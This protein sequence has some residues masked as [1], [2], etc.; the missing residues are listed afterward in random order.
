MK[1][2]T[3]KWASVLLGLFACMLLSAQSKNAALLGSWRM[4]LPDAPYGY[5]EG[6]VK[7]EEKENKLM[8]ISNTA[9]GDITLG[10]LKL[11]KDGKSYTCDFYAEG[12]SVSMTFKL[13]EPKK[14][15]GSVFAEG[16][17]MPLYMTKIEEAEK[18]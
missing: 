16:M 7:I 8:A 11:S 6:T 3:R 13:K 1:T 17:T 2:N 14:I 15:E 12:A 5:Q 10:E 9:S 4:S 18:K